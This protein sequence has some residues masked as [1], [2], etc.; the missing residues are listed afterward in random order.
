MLCSAATLFIAQIYSFRYA[1]IMKRFFIIV[2]FFLFST[3]AFAEEIEGKAYLRKGKKELD[4]SRHEDAIS[5]L[6][7]AEKE[8]PL[9]GDY[10][11]LWLSEAYHENGNHAESLKAIRS[12]LKKYPDS[13][14]IKKTRSA[15][16]REAAE[17]SE[18]CTG[19][20]FES[21]LSDYSKDKEMTY[22]YAK[23]LKKQGQIQKA[24]SLFK[25]IYIKAGAFADLAYS[26]L[27]QEDIS[28]EDMLRRAS[29]LND[30]LDFKDA[31]SLLRT[32]LLKD[33]GVLKYAILEK[34]GGSLFKQKKYRE[35]AEAYKKAGE[36]YWEVRSLYR[37]REKETVYSLIDEL[38]TMKDPRVASLLLV[39]AADKRRE[40]NKKEALELYQK[41][42]ESFPRNR[43]DTLWG[44][45]WTHYLSGDFT[46][47]AEI[48]TT[49]Y[50]MNDSP[51]YLYWKARSLESAGEHVKELYPLNSRKGSDFYSLLS[52]A[53]TREV[54]QDAEAK[55][56][57][58]IGKA[59]QPAKGSS[60]EFKKM[61]RVEV[62]LEFGLTREAVAEMIHYSKKTN[63]IEDI[64]SLCS[65][66]E[67]LGEYKHSVRLAA[68]AP[69]SEQHK[70]FLYPLAYWDTVA[71]LSERYHINPFL[72]LS[73][74]RE[75]SRFN[76]E[77]R[78][79]A[80]ALG[81]MQLMP[82][83]AYR[84][85]RTMQ[86][87]I[88][89]TEDIFHIKNNLHLGISYLSQLI[90]EFGSYAHA[91]AAYNAGEEAVRKWKLNGQYKAIDEFIEDIPY[92]ETRNYVKR[93]LTSFFEYNRIFL[94][95]EESLEDSLEKL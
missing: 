42:L 28:T 5:S 77:A 83:T 78:S 6:S 39:V 16:I 87:E 34:L 29:N 93:V 90:K 85:D 35:A 89:N 92:T 56:F 2:L 30:L 67:E 66:F 11:L 95:S 26:E 9:L 48:F 18:T 40:G 91:I 71:P 61:D 23:W 44:I 75:E 33:D 88:H 32:A 12:L 46:K 59:L 37:A 1:N 31:E 69:F 38:I 53:R 52:Y 81:L 64:V 73:I 94:T 22:L 72:V 60:S 8:F 27:S 70:K 76:V 55:T 80:G 45:G 7:M 43:E 68:N 82:Q 20:L 63:S 17:L 21:Y 14:F 84:L 25:D 86:L 74:I 62:L 65:K 49:L 57:Q 79:P 15:E 4:S 36:R 10:A 51:Q 13:P 47:S 41:V 54:W 19:E 50:S 3:S 58:K 24:K